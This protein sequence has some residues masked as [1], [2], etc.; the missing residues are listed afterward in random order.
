MTPYDTTVGADCFAS[1]RTLF[2]LFVAELA[3]PVT[4]ELSHAELEALCEGRG[5]Q[6][7]RQLLQ[8]H[9]DLRAA[10]EEAHLAAEHPPGR[11]EKGHHRLL[12][13][14]VGTVTVRRCA[15]RAPGRRNR[16]PADDLLALPAGRHSHGLARLAVIEAVR[17][18]FDAARAAII[19]RCGNVIGKRQIEEAVVAA[20]ADVDAFYG[21]RV[22]LPRTAGELLVLSTD[23][24]GVV[25]RPQA[26]RPAT[27]KAAARH[28]GRFHTR[29]ASGEKPYRKRMATLVVVYDA[30]PAPRRPHDVVSLGERS[31][32]RPVR[33]GPAA[34]G[35]WIYGSVIDSAE[36][37]IAVMFDQA[38]A[39]DS[40]HARTWVVLADGDHHQIQLLQSEAER[41]RVPI[42]IVCDLIH[43]LEYLWRGARC[44]HAADDPAAEQR[45][46]GWAL[47]LLAGR[48]NDVIADLKAQAA[49]LPADR[50]RRPQGRCSLPDQPPRLPPL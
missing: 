25:M 1:S 49:C 24:K 10:R 20:A 45:V 47:G 7:V 3:D 41:R 29:L 30:V 26:L 46:A 28:R 40:I 31:G 12:A 19:D 21:A 18:S 44:L 5:R 23:G 11:L 43:V 50:A 33:N 38:E 15:L 4:G 8:D 39:R 36:Q 13:T 37:V 14:V 42:H 6:V 22:P 34:T 27:R 32:D 16:Y 9:L 48:I 35:K 2:E 17:G